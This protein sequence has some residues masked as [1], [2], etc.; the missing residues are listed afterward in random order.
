[1]KPEEERGVVV[2]R[3]DGST[4]ALGVQ[5]R[6]TING[7][8]VSIDA[9][10]VEPDGLITYDASAEYGRRALGADAERRSAET[11]GL[12]LSGAP[13][14]AV[15]ARITWQSEHGTPGVKVL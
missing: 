11:S 6:L 9:G 7:E 14:F 1:M 3:N 12:I 15:K 4:R 10:D 2:F 5:V 8:P 13:R